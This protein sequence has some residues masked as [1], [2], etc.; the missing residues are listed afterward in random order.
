MSIKTKRKPG[1]GLYFMP[2]VMALPIVA[3]MALAVSRLWPTLHKLL[4]IMIKLVVKA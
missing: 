3:V 4:S 2:L 1:L